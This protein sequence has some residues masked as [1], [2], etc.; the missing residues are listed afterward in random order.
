MKTNLMI[1]ATLTALSSTAIPAWSTIHLAGV[2]LERGTARATN[3]ETTGPRVLLASSDD[4][5]EAGSDDDHGSNGWGAG[6]DE[7]HSDGDDH[8]RRKKH[9]DD[10]DS[11][12]GGSRTRGTAPAPAGSVAPPANGLFQGNTPPRVQ[13][14]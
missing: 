12:D 3:E 14:N 8:N 4:H 13:M 2:G 1:L 10:D 9:G 7:R 6:S 5:D 11:D